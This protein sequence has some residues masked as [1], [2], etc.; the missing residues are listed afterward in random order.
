MA[1][2]KGKERESKQL[3]A[4]KQAEE[5]STAELLAFYKARVGEPTTAH[6]DGP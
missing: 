6:G 3:M 4:A 1:Q 2:Q 5:Q